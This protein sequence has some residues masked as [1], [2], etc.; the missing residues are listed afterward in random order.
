[1]VKRLISYQTFIQNSL[2]LFDIIKKNIDFKRYNY[3]YIL[4]NTIY[5]IHYTLYNFQFTFYKIQYTL[6]NF[7]FTFCK[8]H[9]SLFNRNIQ[10]IFFQPQLICFYQF[11]FFNAFCQDIPFLIFDQITIDVNGIG[12]L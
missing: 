6:Y 3:L 4:Q 11:D 7:K 9:Y 2:F 5:I 10:N 1:M 8:T 12:F